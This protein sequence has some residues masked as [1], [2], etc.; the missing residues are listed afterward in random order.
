VRA[1]AGRILDAVDRQIRELV[2]ARTRMRRTLRDWDAALADT[3]AHER[4]HLLERLAAPR[5]ARTRARR[6]FTTSRH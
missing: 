3:P 6:G 1:A 2:S 4:A 5:G